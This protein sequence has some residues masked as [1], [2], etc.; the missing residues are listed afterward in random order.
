MFVHVLRVRF[1]L[2][3]VC[4]GAAE[5]IRFGQ[6]KRTRQKQHDKN[7]QESGG[8][9]TKPKR[10]CMERKVVCVEEMAENRR[11]RNILFYTLLDF[12]DPIPCSCWPYVCVCGKSMGY[13]FRSPLLV[14][15]CAR[16]TCETFFSFFSF[17]SGMFFYVVDC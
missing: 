14:F 4:T 7:S 8:G 2:W 6:Q 17:F 12:S 10:D 16:G 9:I 5:A 1:S 13:I 11:T 3:H 15:P